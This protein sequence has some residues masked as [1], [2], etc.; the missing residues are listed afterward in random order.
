[1]PGFPPACGQCLAGDPHVG[2]TS[3]GTHTLRLGEIRP[4]RFAVGPRAFYLFMLLSF[5]TQ[6]T[7]RLT[8]LVGLVDQLSGLMAVGIVNRVI[9]VI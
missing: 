8:V 9:A 1:M 7:N 4:V 3:C 6:G 5:I 2:E